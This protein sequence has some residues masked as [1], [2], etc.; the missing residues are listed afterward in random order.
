MPIT[1]YGRI[2]SIG[3]RNKNDVENYKCLECLNRTYRTYERV[4][5]SYG[6]YKWTPTG[7]RCWNCGAI[8]METVR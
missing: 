7:W 2:A 3:G 5:D 8:Y 4:A 1:Q 6:H